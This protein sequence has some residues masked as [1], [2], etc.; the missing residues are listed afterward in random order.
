MAL[1]KAFIKYPDAKDFSQDIKNAIDNQMRSD[2]ERRVPFKPER[3]Y[4]LA[5]ERAEFYQG[6]IGRH[7]GNSAGQQKAAETIQKN[8]ETVPSTPPQGAQGAQTL[9]PPANLKESHQVFER[10]MNERM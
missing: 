5:F 6:V 2:A 1:E 10:L 4:Q 8:R 3:Y 9:P 7:K